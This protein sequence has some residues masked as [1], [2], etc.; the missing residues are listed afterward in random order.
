MGQQ[1]VALILMPLLLIS[2][3]LAAR[4]IVLPVEPILWTYLAVAGTLGAGWVVLCIGA[5]ARSKE[6]FYRKHE[7]P[8]LNKEYQDG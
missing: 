5:V 3:P 8:L 7:R 4:E 1:E 6:A 2:L